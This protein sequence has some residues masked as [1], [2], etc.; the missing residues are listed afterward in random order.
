MPHIVTQIDKAEVGTPIIA[1]VRDV[2]PHTGPNK[3]FER[4][5][6]YITLTLLNSRIQGCKQTAL[7]GSKS[8]SLLGPKKEKKLIELDS[9]IN[10]MD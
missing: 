10:K 8:F 4:Q 3:A 5:P 6:V 7:N 1:M 2:Q 9:A